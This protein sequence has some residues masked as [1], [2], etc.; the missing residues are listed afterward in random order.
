M[1]YR[2]HPH[3]G[4]VKLKASDVAEAATLGVPDHMSRDLLNRD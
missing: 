1:G 4:R 3:A 2:V